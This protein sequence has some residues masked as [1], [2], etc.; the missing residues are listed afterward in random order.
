MLLALYVALLDGI[1]VQL[2]IGCCIFAP[3]RG[4][5]MTFYRHFHIFIF[6]SISL[7]LYLQHLTGL[8]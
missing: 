3:Q 5:Y 7:S 1:V 8:G 2:L 4:E 6:L